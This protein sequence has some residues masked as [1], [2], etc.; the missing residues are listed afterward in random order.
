METNEVNIERDTILL[1]LVEL[2]S[3]LELDLVIDLRA[4]REN[5][6]LSRKGIIIERDFV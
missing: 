3:L 2:T 5:S 1:S 6:L 4:A